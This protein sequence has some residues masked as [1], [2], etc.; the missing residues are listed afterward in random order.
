MKAFNIGLF[1][2]LW[3]FM[4]LPVIVGSMFVELA[5]GGKYGGLFLLLYFGVSS[6]LSFLLGYNVRK[7]VK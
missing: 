2:I 6:I 5:S 3:V 4:P 7:E 1:F